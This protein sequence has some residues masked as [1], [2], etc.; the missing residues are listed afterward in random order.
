MT[1]DAQ[2]VGETQGRSVPQALLDDLVRRVLDAAHPLRIILFGSAA[3]GTMGPDSDIDLLVVVSDGTPCRQ[4]SRALYVGNIGF[5]F[6]TDFVVATEHDLLAH[7]S[8]PGSIL[9]T[10]LEEGR[11]LYVR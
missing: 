7:A 9:P 8:D 2:R 3:K 5:G 10:A 6:A 1:A 4:I 11:V